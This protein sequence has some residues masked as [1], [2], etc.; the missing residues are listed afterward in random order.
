MSINLFCDTCKSSM[1]TRSKRCKRCGNDFGTDKKY[2]VVVK[3]INGRR[4]TKILDSLPDAKKYE[5]KLRTEL[6]DNSLYGI[7]VVP[8]IDDVWKKYIR[9]AKS[10][11]KSW[12]E[13]LSRWEHHIQSHVTGRPMDKISA[14]DVQCIVA[15]MKSKRDYAPATIK[16]VIVLIKRIYHWADEIDLYTGY[17]PTTKVK[18]PKLNNEVTECLTKDEIHRLLTTLDGWRNKKAAL[19]VKFALYT[20]LR[21]GELFKLQ[22]KNVD[23]ENG[24]IDLKD[25]KGG[26]DTKLPISNDAMTI[27]HDVKRML[28]SPTCPHVFPN[29]YG[30]QRTTIGNTWTRIK[31]SAKIPPEFRFH[32]IRHTFASYLASSGKVSQYTLQKLLTHKTP[33]MTQ[34][35]AHLFDQT[36]KDGANVMATLI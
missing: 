13:D 29:R 31:K 25:T 8:V 32:G 4:K 30:N 15:T 20:G 6:S 14:Y 2:R 7:T 22:W 26:K 18:L 12:Q 28:P 36:L 35:Y 9:W 27:L 33:Q 1:S 19:L 5:A 23:L 21:R 11:K 17:N 3:G 34:R 24:W 10:N 16:H